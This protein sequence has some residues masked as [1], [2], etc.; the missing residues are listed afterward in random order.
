MIDSQY[1]VVH[2]NSE[3][4]RASFLYTRMRDMSVIRS[5]ALLVLVR[6]FQ[7]LHFVFYCCINESPLRPNDFVALYTEMS[8]KMHHIFIVYETN[9]Y[10]V[11]LSPQSQGLLFWERK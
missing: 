5:Q 6:Q 11:L 4:M 2:R 8:H 7:G 10:D 9:V 3:R 1:L